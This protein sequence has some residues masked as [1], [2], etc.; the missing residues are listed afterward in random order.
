MENNIHSVVS[1]PNLSDGDRPSR[2]VSGSSE[3]Y[4]GYISDRS[5]T[6]VSCQLHT[7]QGNAQIFERSKWLKYLSG[8]H[9]EGIGETCHLRTAHTLQYGRLTIQIRYIRK[10]KATRVLL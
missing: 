4:V 9:Y 6:A 1:H 7:L 3:S 8:P 2:S 10:E 5:A